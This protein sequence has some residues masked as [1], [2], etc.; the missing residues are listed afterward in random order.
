[1]SNGL[2]ESFEPL[3]YS[4]CVVVRNGVSWSA[5]VSESVM[6]ER[7]FQVAGSRARVSELHVQFGPLG[8]LG[9]CPSGPRRKTLGS[10]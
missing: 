1:M 5:L 6:L 2:V 3:A 8:H 9:G 4:G 10:S 7:L